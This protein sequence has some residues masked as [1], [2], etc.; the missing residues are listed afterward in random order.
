MPMQQQDG[1]QQHDLRPEVAGR[2]V[3]GAGIRPGER[4]L[5]AGAGRGR[6]SA[7]LLAAGA[8]VTAL[9]LDPERVAELHGAFAAE[10]ADGRLEVIPGD[11]R[12]WHAGFRGPWRVVANPP[13]NLT[14][15][16]LRRWLLDPEPPHELDL[17]L[18]RETAQKLTGREG[19]HT[20]TSALVACAGRADV[21]AFLRRDATDPP[22]RVDMAAWRFRRHDDARSEMLVEV[23]ALLARVFAGPHTVADALRGIASAVQLR[24]QAAEFGWDPQAHPR[25]IAPRAWPPLARLLAMCGKLR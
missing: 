8:R 13:F 21:A 1:P 25:T 20:R 7:A 6:I 5:D 14:A 10:I 4:V 16:L 11:L 24:R 12:R 17:I 22:S 18:Q 19:S 3:R 15:E 2:L 9:E 23:D